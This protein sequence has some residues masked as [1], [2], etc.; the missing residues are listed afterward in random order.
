MGTG[1]G[2]STWWERDR[3]LAGRFSEPCLI[4]TH[5]QPVWAWLAEASLCI[6]IN[7]ISENMQSQESES[8]IIVVILCA[9]SLNTGLISVEMPSRDRVRSEPCLHPS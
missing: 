8:L 6:F 7:S 1:L 3:G 4:R 9:F 2:T 5:L